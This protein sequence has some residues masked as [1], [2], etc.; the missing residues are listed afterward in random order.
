MWINV[1][2]EKDKKKIIHNGMAKVMVKKYPQVIIHKTATGCP[3][4]IVD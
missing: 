3:Q 4:A 1:L 2:S